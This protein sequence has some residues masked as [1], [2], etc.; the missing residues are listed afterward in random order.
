MTVDSRA[1]PAARP[2]M[3]SLGLAALGLAALVLALLWASGSFARLGWWALDQQRSVQTL[4][5]RRIHDMRAGEPF[6]FFGLVTLCAGYGFLHAVGPGHGKVLVAGAALGTRAGAARMGGIALAGSLAQALVAILVVYGGFL[7]FQASARGTVAASDAWLEPLGHA[8][9]APIGAWLLSRGLWTFRPSS[10]DACACGH[11]HGPDPEAAMAAARLREMAAL[12]GAMAIR[13][14][15]GALFVLVIAWRL[16]LAAAGAAAVIAM[17]IGTAA[18]T[19]LVAWLAV[20]GREAALLSAG[21]GPF[22][23]RLA[24]GLQIGAG[25]LILVLSGAMLGTVLAR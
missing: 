14:C 13:P 25:T 22:A 19:V 4:L 16:D 2:A 6:A 3:R 8:A 7:I 1:L 24:G 11:A 23:R 21:S 5:A 20:G 15:T 17:G 9:V 18:F 12:V 10:G